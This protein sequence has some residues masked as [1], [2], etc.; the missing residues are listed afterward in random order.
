[1]FYLFP[2][3]LL[4][5]LIVIRWHLRSI[6]TYLVLEVNYPQHINFHVD[7]DIRDPFDQYD[8]L[9]IPPYLEDTNNKDDEKYVKAPEEERESYEEGEG[10]EDDEFEVTKRPK[11]KPKESAINNSQLGKDSAV[12]AVEQ[13]RKTI[14]K[15]MFKSGKRCCCFNQN[16]QQRLFV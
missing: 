3:I 8:N 14:S 7:L 9:Q 12:A 13:E 2:L 6:Y 4:S 1:M 5:I 16:R 15:W 10:E 11:R